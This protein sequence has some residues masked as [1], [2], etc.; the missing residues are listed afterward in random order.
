M[1]SQLI[2]TAIQNFLLKILEDYGRSYDLT[3]ISLRYFNASGASSDGLIGDYRYPGRHLIEL[4]FDATFPENKPLIIYGNDYPTHDGT[5]LRDFIHVEDLAI[6]HVI[7][8]KRMIDI[9]KQFTEV[10][11][12]ANGK[13]YSV[14]E[15]VNTVQKITNKKVNFIFGK[16]RDCDPPILVADSSKALKELGWE[17]KYKEIEIIIEHAWNWY[18]K[19]NFYNLI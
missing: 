5:C 10:Y 19:Q 17:T 3:S 12:L 13:G 15:I 4:A 7:S 2:H 1:K 9:E 11:N 6:A 14:M 18:K 16:R 8:L